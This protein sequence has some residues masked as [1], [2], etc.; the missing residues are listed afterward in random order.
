MS[1]IFADPSELYAI[2]D[3]IDRHADAVRSNATTLA[4]AIAADRWRGLAAHVFATEAGSVLKDMW[5]CARRL[6]DAA[7]ALRRH[8]RRVQGVLDFVRRAWDDVEGWGAAV[9]CD[10]GGFLVGDDGLLDAALADLLA[11][12]PR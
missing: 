8:A 1:V 2:A 12:V 11:Q 10:L 4:A 6:N 9:A 3:R 5:A 7:D